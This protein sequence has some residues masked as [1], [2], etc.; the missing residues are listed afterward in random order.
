MRIRFA[1]S[2]KLLIAAGLLIVSLPGYCQENLASLEQKLT[3]G[4]V[5]AWTLD[6]T[7][8]F[9]GTRCENGIIYTFKKRAGTSRAPRQ[10][11][12]KKCQNGKWVA[13]NFTWQMSQEGSL[14]TVL[15]VGGDT[16]YYLRFV[17][18]AGKEFLRLRR[19]G[20]DKSEATTDYY[21][22][23]DNS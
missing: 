1:S 4:N 13:Q 22:Y 5:R 17:Q 9:L 16:K 12:V 21:F 15:L 3:G 8:K 11:Q 7:K 19:M 14:D 23:H 6:S 20:K 18:R 2:T 10:M